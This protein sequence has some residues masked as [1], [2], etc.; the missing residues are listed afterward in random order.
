MYNPKS[1]PIYSFIV[2]YYL[3]IAKLLDKLTELTEKHSDIII[4]LLLFSDL[5]QP[6]IRRVRLDNTSVR[7]SFHVW[8]CK[9]HSSDF[10]EALL[11]WSLRG[12]DA[13]SIDDDSNFKA[14]PYTGSSEHG[15]FMRTIFYISSVANRILWIDCIH[16]AR[17]IQFAS[18]AL[19][20]SWRTK[21]V[22]GSAVHA[23]PLLFRH[24]CPHQL[25]WL[26]YLGMFLFIRLHYIAPACPPP[27]FFVLR[28]D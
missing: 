22:P 11:R 14:H 20:F 26:C 5:R 24:L 2:S 9:W 13:W 15:T 19:E 25:R 3:I 12:P 18:T 10:V 16:F 17:D 7:G 6:T 28:K 27:L 1:S 4:S 8:C 23:V 21:F